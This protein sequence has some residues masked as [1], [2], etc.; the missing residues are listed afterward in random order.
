MTV[1]EVDS[2]GGVDFIV[3]EYVAGKTL[4][5]A[6][7][8][9]G[10]RLDQV[11][12]VAIPIADALARAHAAGIV[13]RDLKPAN[14]MVGAEGAVKVLDF[15]L[16]KLLTSRE[17]SLKS[18]TSTDDGMRGPLS[19]PGTVAGTIG[20]MSPEQ[21]TGGNVD[22]RSDVFSFGALLY[23]MATGRRAFA[24]GSTAE[25]LAALMKEQPKAPSEVVPDLPKELDRLIQRCLR[26]EPERRFQHMLDAKLELEQIKEESET[27]THRGAGGGP[28]D[29]CAW[30]VAGVV[31]LLLTAAAAW[32]LTRPAPPPMRVVSLTSTRGF[33]AFPA[34]SPDGK[35]VAFVWN[36][37]Q[38]SNMDVYV[39][40]IGSP[41]VLR[42]TTDPGLD[43]MPSWSPDGRQ[44][45]FLRTVLPDFTTTIRL[46][47]PLGG[48]DRK[49]SDFFADG[50]A[51]VVPRRSRAGR[52]ARPSRPGPGADA[53]APVR[54][55]L[56][57]PRGER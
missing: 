11:L 27:G 45:A 36:G 55:S 4:A 25:V 54:R 7:P 43:G 41:E 14:V 46:I 24:G 42:L 9:Q 56:P 26:K 13:H 1:H 15:G 12:K 51:G 57:R 49:V 48:A 23:E 21:A 50:E 29:A 5:D 10:M 35:Q 6:I 52:R 28:L 3:M 20:Y 8:R 53:W 47:S 31:G 2:V 32:L 39:T 22:T 38:Q 30:L 19:Q 40:T 18:E 34:L 16:A 44:I 33:E 17:A 37:E